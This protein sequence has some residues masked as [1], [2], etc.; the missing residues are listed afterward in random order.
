M[1]FAILLVEYPGYGRSSGAPSQKGIERA[2]CEAYDRALERGE[3]DGERIL[4]LGRSVGTGAA[5]AL[6]A[7]RPSRALLLISPF[8]SIVA[9]A[10]RRLVSS[11]LVRDPF[12]NLSVVRGYDGPVQLVHGREDRLNPYGHSL[13]LKHAAKE[14]TLLSYDAAHNDCP[15]DW[16]QVW[17]DCRGFLEEAGFVGKREGETA[18]GLP[19]DRDGK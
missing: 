11:R 4:F 13:K 9:H 14:A 19:L 3:V 8:T 15:P 18:A 6:A 2:F 5:C 10:H 16:E 7:L 12:D 1:G 17:E